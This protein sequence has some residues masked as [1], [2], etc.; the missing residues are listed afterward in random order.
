MLLR[1]LRVRCNFFIYYISLAGFEFIY[2]FDCGISVSGCFNDVWY[3]TMQSWL[4]W[5]RSK[6]LCSLFTIWLLQRGTGHGRR[7]MRRLF[8][9]VFWLV[10]DVKVWIFL[11]VW[12]WVCWGF[13]KGVQPLVIELDQPGNLHFCSFY[14]FSLVI[15]NWHLSLGVTK[16]KTTQLNPMTIWHSPDQTAYDTRLLFISLFFLNQI[17]FPLNLSLCVS[18]CVCFLVGSWC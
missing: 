10:L 17:I 4:M 14:E 6:M 2:I 12:N 5:V 11:T 7:H 9:C 15:G 13:C 16:Y 1:E 8:V 18:V 3:L